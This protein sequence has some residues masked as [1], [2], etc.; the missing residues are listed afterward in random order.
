MQREWIKNSEDGLI[1]GVLIWD[2]SAAFDTSMGQTPANKGPDSTFINEGN[3][4]RSNPKPSSSRVIKSIDQTRVTPSQ[5]ES[6]VTSIFD[7]L[8]IMI[9]FS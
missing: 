2:L 4:T 6:Q 8:F 3:S 5:G 7:H 9:R 1:T